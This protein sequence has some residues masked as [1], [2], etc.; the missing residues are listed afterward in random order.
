MKKN[1]KSLVITTLCTGMI[2]ASSISVFAS[3]SKTISKIQDKNISTAKLLKSNETEDILYVYIDK[4]FD[5]TENSS[6]TIKIPAGNSTASVD[7]DFPDRAPCIRLKCINSSKSQTVFNK[8]YM[9]VGHIK[10]EMTMKNGSEYEIVITNL[11]GT[12][13]SGNIFIQYY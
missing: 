5:I 6:T 12:I 11:N 9:D 2:M 7:I 8:T 10:A 3:S 1:I 4:E 13:L